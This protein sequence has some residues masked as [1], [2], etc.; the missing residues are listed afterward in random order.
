MK[1]RNI[2][3]LFLGIFIGV[4]FCGVEALASKESPLAVLYSA[5]DFQ[6]SEGH[7]QGAKELEEITKQIYNSGNKEVSEALICGDYYDS[8][9]ISEDESG[10]GIDNI[11]TVLNRQWG[12]EHDE[13]YFV[14][15]NHD[16]SSTLGLDPTGGT[17]RK[18]YSV[19]Q[20]NHDDY[21]WIISAGVDIETQISE[22]AENLRGWLNE[23]AKAG[24]SKPI[25][26][27]THLP[28]HHSYRYDNPYSEYLFDVLNEAGASGLNIVYL[29]G[30]NHSKEYDNY[31]GGSEVYLS[32]GDEILIP[33]IQGKNAEDYKLEILNFTY[34]NA[35]YI[36]KTSDGVL[37]SCI[38]EIYEDRIEIKRHTKEGICNLKDSGISSENDLGWKE[39]LIIKKSPQIVDLNQGIVSWDESINPEKVLI[40]ID[41]S[42]DLKVNVQNIE[43]Y[44]IIWECSDADIAEVSVDRSDITKARITG[45]KYGTTQ[46]MVTVLDSSQQKQILAKL[47]M[48]LL[49]VPQNAI[50]LS[51]GEYVR[52]Y[53]LVEDISAELAMSEEWEEDY[54]ISNS[55]KTGSIKAFAAQADEYVDTE[56]LQAIYVPG[57]GNVIAENREKNVLWRFRKIDGILN[58]AE[59]YQMQISPKSLFR[60]RY[61]LAATSGIDSGLGYPN[62]TNMR[63]CSKDTS[64]GA[65]VFRFDH[66]PESKNS[67]LTTHHYKDR[68]KENENGTFYFT[69]DDLNNQFVLSNQP[70]R[71]L[72]YFYGRISDEISDVLMWTDA[73]AGKAH[74][75]DAVTEQTGGTIHVMHEGIIEEIPITLGM[76]SGFEEDVSG[77]YMCTLSFNGEVLSESYELDLQKEV[78]NL[79]SIIKRFIIELFD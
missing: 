77:K 57:I 5:S 9:D 4:F 41:K 23:K 58:N 72:V 50:C 61:Y 38:F 43:D 33:D 52:F 70:E 21:M 66:E 76:L 18:H 36:G 16:P 65:A 39:N 35:G 15:G 62:L 2:I 7:A 74:I 29:F 8:D 64:S 75:G 34:M 51:Y 55:E 46:I 11:Y 19:Y 1:C 10:K 27:I 63:T 79:F 49:V 13:I 71:A 12:L 67:L 60:N 42:V 69:Y 45:K 78:N 56:E 68:F 25:F 40:D 6:N 20:I 48:R 31:L 14:Q 53:G 26:I 54:I 3:V 73:D 59:E 32:K 22:T 30:H 24:D 17:D 37:S 28:L 47:E 44:N